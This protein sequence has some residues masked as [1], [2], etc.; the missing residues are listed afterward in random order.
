MS[1]QLELTYNDDRW[2]TIVSP[3]QEGCNQYLEKV[4]LTNKTALHIGIGNSS[5]YA[6]FG[7]VLSKLDGITIMESEI[8]VAHSL[9]KTCRYKLFKINKYNPDSILLLDNYDV[10]VDNNLKQHACCPFHWRVYF[11][12]ILTKLNPNGFLLTHTQG[13]APHSDKIDSLSVDEL[14]YL[15]HGT[16]YPVTEKKDFKNEWGFYPVIIKHVNLS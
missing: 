1:C 5:V 12:N 9:V 3:D 8:L 14:K 13:F 15:T 2:A 7:N 6:K 4:Y 10:I 16:N 11:K